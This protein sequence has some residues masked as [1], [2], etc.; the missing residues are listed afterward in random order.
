MNVLVV[1]L[2]L[3]FLLSSVASYSSAPA[4]ASSYAQQ[5]TS[6]ADE[7]EL[8]EIPLVPMK[9][10]KDYFDCSK[11]ELSTLLKENIPTQELIKKVHQADVNLK[12]LW[13]NY[14]NAAQHIADCKKQEGIHDIKAQQLQLQA[15]SDAY[16]AQDK[17]YM[18][19]TKE[20]Q[21]NHQNAWELFRLA[22]TQKNLLFYQAVVLRAREEEQRKQMQ[23]KEARIEQQAIQI[24]QLVQQLAAQ[25]QSSQNL[26]NKMEAQ[27]RQ[28][29]QQNHRLQQ[30]LEQFQPGASQ[31]EGASN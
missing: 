31:A 23:E 26:M 4:K 10:A 11:N 7:F 18:N 20:G 25:N 3:M 12:K 1:N 22:E 21:Q 13:A 27:N 29:M 8:P 17:E 9:A 15:L 28:L 24:Q 16:Y 19:Y 30:T 6:D 14:S 2:C 5:N